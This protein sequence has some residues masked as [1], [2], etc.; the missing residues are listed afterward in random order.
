MKEITR[1]EEKEKER[2]IERKIIKTKK[3]KIK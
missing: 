2:F 3:I 1:K